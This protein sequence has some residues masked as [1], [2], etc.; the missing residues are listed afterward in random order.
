MRSTSRRITI[1]VDDIA[2]AP[3]STTAACQVV[4]NASA[5]GASRAIVSTTC[6]PPKPTTRPRIWTRRG[7]LNSSPSVNI[8]NTTPNSASW[9]VA[10][11]SAT[12]PSACGPIATPTSR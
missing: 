6:E 12:H 11:L 10:G 5:T 7:R 8:R 2:S 1:A 3:A 4:P 9:R